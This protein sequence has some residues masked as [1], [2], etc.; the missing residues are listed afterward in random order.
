TGVSDDVTRS[1]LFKDLVDNAGLSWT[2]DYGT[3]P[4]PRG[5]YGNNGQPRATVANWVNNVLTG[6]LR[7]QAEDFD[8]GGEGVACHAA[9]GVNS[10]GLYRPSE[11]VDITF[12]NDTGGGFKVTSTA[13]GEWMEYT[14]L[15][16]EP[17]YYDVALRYA[18][19]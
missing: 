10:G 4:A 16:R 2:P 3:W 18:A 6:T 15:V 17:G 13:D 5:V 11:P 14:I 1:E 9:D 8:T 12:C 19:P 7:I